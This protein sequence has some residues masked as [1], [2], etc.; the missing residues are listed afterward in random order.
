AQDFHFSQYGSSFTNFNPALTGGFDGKYRAHIHSRRQWSNLI[1]TSYFTNYLSFDLPLNGDNK[2]NYPSLGASI[3]SDQIGEVYKNVNINLSGSFRMAPLPNRNH[4][5]SIG[6]EAGLMQKSIDVNQL[7][8]GNQYD[9]KTGSYDQSISSEAV[10]FGNRGVINNLDI[11]AGILYNFASK[12]SLVNPYV[13]FSTFHILQPKESFYDQDYKLPM[14]TVAHAGAKINMLPKV[15]LVP[16]A[17]FMQQ[18]VS[19]MLM[20]DVY[21]HIR[22]NGFNTFLIPGISYRNAD[23]AILHFGITK[24]KYSGM[25]SYDVN[26]SSL[27]AYTNYQGAME[28]SFTYLMAKPTQLPKLNSCP[29]L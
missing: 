25:I 5:I 23:A 19:Q 27:S 8:F 9:S 16:Q 18:G 4:Q 20:M 26:V 28:F 14:R 10:L 2:F 11:N 24:G 15:Q 22:L 7:Y 1:S 13:G 6:A 29:S 12:T 21:A 3:I 17:I